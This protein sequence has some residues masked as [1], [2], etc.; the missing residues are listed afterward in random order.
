MAASA[1]PASPDARAS[2]IR[3]WWAS[4]VSPGRSQPVTGPPETW[5]AAET[6]P[7]K[8]FEHPVARGLDEQGVETSVGA[9]EGDRVALPRRV[10]HDLDHVGEPLLDVVPAVPGGEAGREGL[11]GPAELGQ[12]TTLIVALRTEGTP[13]DDVGIEQVPVTDRPTRV[14]TLGRALTS[15][16]ASRTRRDSRTTVRETSKRWPISSGTR[17]RSAPRSP[18]TIIWPSCWTSWPWRPRPRLA[19]PRRVARPSS[20][21]APPQARS[22]HARRPTPPDTGSGRVRPSLASRPGIGGAGGGHHGVRK[23]THA[24]FV[25]AAHP[26]LEVFGEKHT[27]G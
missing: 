6:M 8:V 16:L 9:G 10:P 21:L 25:G 4:E 24:S 13:F 26:P 20:E 1:A 15:P 14:P 18:E 12:L 19:E 11:D 23:G 2:A 17:G 27:K 22:R 7:E 3:A 5:R